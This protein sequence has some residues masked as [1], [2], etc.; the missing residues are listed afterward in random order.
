[1]PQYQIVKDGDEFFILLHTLL[2]AHKY[3]IPYV[4]LRAA[5]GVIL[6]WQ[7]NDCRDEDVSNWQAYNVVWEG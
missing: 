3:L 7:G 6:N 2:Q 5:R 1:M 4:S